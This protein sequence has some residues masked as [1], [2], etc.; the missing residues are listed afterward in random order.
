MVAARA[1]GTGS[2]TGPLEG[3]VFAVSPFNFTSI[4]GNLPTAP[5]LM[6]NTVLWKPASTSVLSNYYIM[7]LL[8]AAGLPDGV[9]NFLPGTGAKVGDPVIAHPDFAGIHFTGSTPVFQA[10]W[11][12][13][14]GEHRRS[15]APTRGS[16]ARPG[17]R[18][19]SSPT[20][21]RTSTALVDGARPRRLRV[22]G[23]EVL[24]GLARLRAAL[25]VGRASRERLLD[26]IEQ[27]KMGAPLDFR[28]FMAAVIDENSFDRIMGY[29]DH[30][31]ELERR[32]R[33]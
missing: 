2:S 20:P 6:G 1:S 4:G 27:I 26:E 12:T 24:G 32:P 16:S 17:A 25:A 22:P 11:K 33:S 29:I 30:A 19:S 10:M 9:I 7:K 21:R 3:F 23:A 31:Q 5:A 18:T 28:N 8:Q 13:I 15:T 14:G